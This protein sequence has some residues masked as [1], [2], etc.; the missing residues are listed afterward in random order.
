MRKLTSYLFISLDGVVEAPNAF[1]RDDL[2]Q[3]LDLFIDETLA[4]QDTVLLG[5]RTYEE[6]S[7]FWPDSKIE[8]FATFINNVPKYVASSPPSSATTAALPRAFE[9]TARR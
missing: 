6:W 5:R 8:P 9:L 3:D 2:Y 1:L 4:E 7:R